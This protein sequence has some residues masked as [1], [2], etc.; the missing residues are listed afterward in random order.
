MAFRNRDPFGAE[1]VVTYD[2][3]DLLIVETRDP[4]DNRVTIGERDSAGNLTLTGNDYRVLQ[5]RLMMDPNRNRAAVA[6]DALGLVVGTAVMGKPE[7]NL[8][9]SLVGFVADLDEAVTLSHLANPFN[10]PHS[11]LQQ[12]TTRLVYDLFA[13][14][15]TQ[16]DPNPQPI[17]AYT[18]AR[19]THAADLGAGEQ[20]R[21]QQTFSYSDGFEREIQKK[22]Q[23]EPGPLALDSPNA[24]IVDPRWTGSGWTIFNNKGK[25][26]RQYEPFFSN[27][28]R[29]E[30]AHIVGVSSV[31]FYDPAGR[32]V[33]TLHPNHTYEKAVFAPWHQTTWDVNDTVTSDPRTDSDIG[34]YTAAYF[35]AQP[36]TWQT[37]QAERQGGA[38]G[39]QEQIAATKAVAHANTPTTA[40]FDT[41][42]RPFLTLA[43]NGFLPGGVPDLY[44]TRVELDI[45]GNQRAVR[46]AIVQAGD[47]QGRV[48]MRYDYDL[49][50]NRIHQASMEAGDRWML[51]NVAGNPV[52][53]WDSLGHTFRTTYDPLRRPVRSFVVGAD[54]TNPTQEILTERL[55]YG[56]QHPQTESLNLRG[57][58]YAHFDQAGVATS[59]AYDF[60]GSLLESARRLEQEYRQ[61]IDWSDVDAVIP[62]DAKVAFN[63]IT[64]ESAL[65]PRLESDRFT[66]RTTYD[67]LNRP[68]TIETP[69]RSVIRPRYNEANLLE[70][71]E[72][73]LQG[74]AT[75]T[76]FVNDI[77]YDAKGQR[78]LIEYGN[79]VRT[80]YS[81][82]PLSFRLVQLQTLRG[83]EPLQDMSYTYDPTGNITH[84]RDAAQQTLY[85]RNQRV[86]PSN[87]YTY[88][89]IYRLVEATGREHLGQTG[90]QRNAP[91]LPDAFNS[92]HT[93]LAYPGD[94]NAMGRYVEQYVYD[95]VG[96][97]LSMQHRGTDPAHSGWTRTYAYTEASLI[98]PTKQSNR[99]SST[100]IAGAIPQVEPYRHDAHGNMT[101]MPH[102]EN[103]SDPDA[104]NMHWDY[105]DQLRHVD[106]G[107]GGTAYY[108]YDASGQR[109]RKVWEKSPALV[110]E[111]IYLG[112]FEIFRRRDRA[113]NVA[114]ERNTLHIMDDQQRITIVETRT[115]DITN[116]DLAPAQLIRYQ[117]GNQL[118]SS[119]VELDS[120]AQIISYEEY[121]PYGSSSYQAVRSQTETSKRYRYTSM[122]RDEETGL[123]YHTARFY[124]A[125]LGRWA[126]C[127]PIGLEGEPHLYEYAFDNPINYD[128]RNG[129]QPPDTDISA[130]S[131]LIEALEAADRADFDDESVSHVLDVID[132]EIRRRGFSYYFTRDAALAH[133]LV[134][135]E[136]YNRHQQLGNY[137]RATFHATL[138][139]IDSFGYALYGD[140]AGETGRNVAISMVVGA[141]LG[142]LS[143]ASRTAQLEARAS[144]E[145]LSA[146][147][148]S[149]RATSS[150]EPASPTTPSPTQPTQTAQSGRPPSSSESPTPPRGVPAA[151]RLV[152]RSV[153]GERYFIQDTAHQRFYAEGTVSSRGELSISI[154]TRLESGVRSTLLRGR[155]Q[156]QRILQFFEGGFTSIKGN[157]QFGSNL[158]RFNE[159]TAQ[160]VAPAEAALQTWTGQQAA[161]AGFRTV[162]VLSLEGSPGE[163]TS[164]QVLFNQ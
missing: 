140:S 115:I 136:A 114:L 85:F 23:A 36:A 6:F 60:K 128:D 15:R 69:D 134:R 124:I 103:H 42:G 116:S 67:A 28:H 106:L 105:K 111:R 55:V 32:V 120:Q 142:R 138:G 97:I 76:P 64:L 29:F 45:E 26:V 34:G 93:Q 54:A 123:S 12:A 68:V 150:P 5:P 146:R 89:A 4:L 73:N 1:S 126:S 75:A 129:K 104:A 20:S 163:Y 52:R 125:W 49:L 107:G 16:N 14:H 160:G 59:E 61:A 110:E 152:D 48:V 41:L 95:A 131:E 122:E 44:A 158:A 92:F 153:P 79:G 66:S 81:Y 78:T 83:A 145:A 149:R 100:T 40:Y 151:P 94:G 62:T 147:V 24:P 38:L 22:V 21:I 19:E 139:V 51:N 56:E 137:G 159:L 86:E 3:Y 109:A 57:Q 63:S 96:N 161:A 141:A 156:F 27:T 9:D 90:G 70:A 43:H 46:D 113:G 119:N 71:V 155:E 117:L 31:L 164:V 102:L 80:T 148:A 8:G 84:I 53:A 108:T 143:A 162:R 74:A 72:A 33:A 101:R 132:Q 11:I 87:D 144:S 13:Y 50:S 135:A 58:L 47:A 99:L 35:A 65:T 39:S 130:S 112:G 17:V 18:L 133:A 121:T 157:W 88:D 98:E 82:D 2:A 30:F 37:W 127:D 118:S 154:R 25:P 7:E 10:D 91:T 77:D